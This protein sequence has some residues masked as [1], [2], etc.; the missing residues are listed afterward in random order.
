MNISGKSVIRTTTITTTTTTNN[1][2]EM[3]ANLT[4][5]TVD[6]NDAID[7]QN[8]TVD[9]QCTYTKEARQYFPNI[10]IDG[11][12]NNNNEEVSMKLNN[13]TDVRDNLWIGQYFSSSL[14]YYCQLCQSISYN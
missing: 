11:N 9:N 14:T 7:N 13:D 10:S 1:D 3:M 6:A 2:D 5:D 12:E 4:D 8:N